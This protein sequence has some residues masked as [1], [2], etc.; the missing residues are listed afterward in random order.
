MPSRFNGSEPLTLISFSAT[1]GF[2]DRSQAP[3]CFRQS[4]LFAA[5]SRDEMAAAYQSRASRLR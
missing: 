5:D 2:P 4:E 3:D 1:G